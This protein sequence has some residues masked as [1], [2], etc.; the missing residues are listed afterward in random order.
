MR[1]LAALVATFFLLAP[2]CFA[3]VEPG[4]TFT[5]KVVEVTDGDTYDVRRSSGQ[6]VTLRLHG[7]DT[8]ES[9]QS[10]GGAATRK[11]RQYVGGKRVRAS[12]EDIGRYGRAVARIEVQ[13]GDLGA[14]LIRDGLGWH[15]E[16]YAPNETEYARLMD[17][18]R[19][20]GRGLW[21]QPNPTPPW[22]WRDRNSGQPENDRDCSDFDT[23]PEAQAFFERHQ[24]GDPHNLDGNGDGVACESLPSGGS[25]QETTSA[26]TDVLVSAAGREAQRE[27]VQVD[28]QFGVGIGGSPQLTSQA[29]YGIYGGPDIRWGRFRI[30]IHLNLMVASYTPEGFN[31]DN[32]V[33]RC[34]GPGGQFTEDSE[35]TAFNTYAWARVSV[36]YDIL[37]KRN[38]ST[39]VYLGIGGDAG[40]IVGVHGVGGVV[41]NRTYGAELRAGPNQIMAGV[42]FLF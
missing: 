23:Q 22:E 11:A 37:T 20:A 8:P 7:V 9:A 3:Q 40:S 19:K 6:T 42:S 14:M 28:G 31:Y 30:P 35:C 34:R 17:Q 38:Q 27:G 21:S 1:R 15:Y 16:Q 29:I 18:A 4:Q 32:E 13:G 26:A 10:Y 41:L 2:A 24:P 36:M 39:R 25:T 12:V 5:A 33:D